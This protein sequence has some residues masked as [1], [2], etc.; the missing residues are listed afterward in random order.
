MVQLRIPLQYF[1][2]PPQDFT[3]LIVC[4]KINIYVAISATL[5]IFL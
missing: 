2:D 1:N 3:Y 4:D 5:C